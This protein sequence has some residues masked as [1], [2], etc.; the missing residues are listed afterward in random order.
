MPTVKLLMS[1]KR[2]KV[3]CLAFFACLL[4]GGSVSVLS[5]AVSQLEL[6]IY[7]APDA[8]SDVRSLSQIEHG[9]YIRQDLDEFQL[10]SVTVTRLQQP[11]NNSPVEELDII[12]DAEAL[13]GG[14]SLSEKY[15]KQ[16]ALPQVNPYS[17][18]KEPWIETLILLLE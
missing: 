1:R 14:S 5:E 18:V 8:S 16:T 3:L 10:S 4:I 15:K 2:V 13:S 12:S 6:S 9:T 11:L 17:S 7:N